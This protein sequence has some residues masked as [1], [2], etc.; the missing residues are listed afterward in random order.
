MLTHYNVLIIED[1]HPAIEILKTF[2]A[3]HDDLVLKGVARFSKDAIALL[4]QHTIDVLFLDINLPDTSG[5]DFLKLLPVKPEVIFTT[6]LRDY[7]AD[8][9]DLD[10]LDYLVKPFSLYRFNKA[11]DK[12]RNKTIVLENSLSQNIVGNKP[13]IYIKSGTASHKVYLEEIQ[14]IESR[15]DY[16]K[17]Y[18]ISS[19]LITRSTL[20]NMELILPSSYFIRVHR[21]FIVNKKNITSLESASISI[22]NRK[23]IPIGK[24]YK[25]TVLGIKL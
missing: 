20:Q 2:I 16:C 5:I 18:F 21:S 25:N 6:A 22:T 10:A 11:I 9:F 7:A 24:K 12:L 15:K 17:I 19:F 13:F 3:K 4:K 14:Y 8:G 23:K 1:E